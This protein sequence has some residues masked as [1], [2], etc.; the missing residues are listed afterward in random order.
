MRYEVHLGGFTHWC[1][2]NTDLQAGVKTLDACIIEWKT[3]PRVPMQVFN[4]DSG[5]ETIVGLAQVLWIQH[6]AAQD[7]PN[8]FPSEQAQ[9]DSTNEWLT[10]V[11]AV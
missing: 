4:L 5:E 10:E 9:L 1:E 2:A 3:F 6:H 7:L 8:N 11:L